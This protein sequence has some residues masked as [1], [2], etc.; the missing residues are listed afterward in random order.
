MPGLQLPQMPC[1]L[2]VYDF[3]CDFSDIVGGYGLR[4]M[5]LYCIRATCDFLYELSATDR[6]KPYDD[7][8]EIVRKSCSHR[9]VSAEMVR[10]PRG[11]AI[12]V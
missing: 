2:F 8:A 5:C 12:V 11:C 4:R 10:S 9:A 6:T 1:E 3:P 7:R